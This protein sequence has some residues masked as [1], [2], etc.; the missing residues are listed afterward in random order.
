MH[1]KWYERRRPRY[2]VDTGCPKKSYSM[3]VKKINRFS[4]TNSWFVYIGCKKKSSFDI[5]I[6]SI[7]ET[8]YIGIFFLIEI[9]GKELSLCK[10][11][12]SMSNL[13]KFDIQITISILLIKKNIFFLKKELPWYW[14]TCTKF[15]SFS[16]RWSSFFCAFFL[17]FY[18]VTFFS[19]TCYDPKSLIWP[20]KLKG[21]NIV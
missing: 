2:C 18:G 11:I 17:H 8:N 6:F 3:K 20:D 7:T 16:T 4:A 1:R 10:D 12:W 15:F 19:D 13:S 9:T 14:W 5:C 21:L